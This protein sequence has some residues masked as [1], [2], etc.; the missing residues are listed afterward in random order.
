MMHLPY[1]KCFERMTEELTQ[2]PGLQNLALYKALKKKVS[3]MITQEKHCILR[4]D[5]CN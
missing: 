3:N 5:I 1:K 4:I 2:G